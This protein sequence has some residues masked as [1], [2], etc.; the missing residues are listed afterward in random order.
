M[1]RCLHLAK[2]CD[3]AEILGAGTAGALIILVATSSGGTSCVQMQ[4]FNFYLSLL[5]FP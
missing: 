5:E 1:G 4:G 2:V 3:L